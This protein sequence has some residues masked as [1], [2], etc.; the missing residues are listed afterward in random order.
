MV[1]KQAPGSWQVSSSSRRRR[2]SRIGM[3]IGHSAGP[4]GLNP[5]YQEECFSRTLQYFFRWWRSLV[6]IIETLPIMA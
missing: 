1:R 2:W 3:V 6:Y 4:S 5:K